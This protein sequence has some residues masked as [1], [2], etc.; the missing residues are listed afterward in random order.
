MRI[1]PINNHR[2]SSPPKTGKSVTIQQNEYK[3]WKSAIFERRIWEFR[4]RVSTTN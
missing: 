1:I 2:S 3:T 4:S